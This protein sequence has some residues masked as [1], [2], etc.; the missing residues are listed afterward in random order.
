MDI[1]GDFNS[2]L[3]FDYTGSG[4]ESEYATA[5][6]DDSLYLERL[7][8]LHEK[9]LGE[10]RAFARRETR[11]FED[12]RWQLYYYLARFRLLTLIAFRA[13]SD[14]RCTMVLQEFI[15]SKPR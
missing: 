4:E 5:M 14:V 13:G 15:R 12:V 3:H 8:T 11:S 10:L 1:G 2:Q 6:S 7:E 9:Q